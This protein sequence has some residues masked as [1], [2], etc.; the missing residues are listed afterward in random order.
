MLIYT[1]VY[2]LVM[3]KQPN[4]TACI[5]QDNTPYKILK[6][7][8]SFQGWYWFVTDYDRDNND[9]AFGYVVGFEKEWGYFSIAEITANKMRV[10]E[11][12][13]MN[14]FSISH[15]TMVDTRKLTMG[16]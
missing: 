5:I 12:P 3:M 10:W 15:V 11:V 1:Y 4:N 2:I 13:E 6:V 16:V 7:Y 9:H 14:W 8:E